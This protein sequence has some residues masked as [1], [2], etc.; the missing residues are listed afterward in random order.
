MKIALLFH[1]D[2]YSFIVLGIITITDR[3]GCGVVKIRKPQKA[4]DELTILLTRAI[5]GTFMEVVE[6]QGILEEFKNRFLNMEIRV[7]YKRR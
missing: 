7:E 1:C 5:F 3:T 4:V 2:H 6:G